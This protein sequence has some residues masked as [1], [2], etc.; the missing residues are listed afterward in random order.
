M[1][2]RNS[3]RHRPAQG[4]PINDSGESLQHTQGNDA[5]DELAAGDGAPRVHHREPA[6]VAVEED[7]SA[8]AVDDQTTSLAQLGLVPGV[9]LP[10]QGHQEIDVVGQRNADLPGGDHDI[11]AAGATA[12]LGPVDLGV[13]GVAPGQDGCFGEDSTGGDHT[14]ATR[15]G[16]PDLATTHR[17]GP[18]EYR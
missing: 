7:G 16:D 6:G 8:T 11:G 12:G 9:R 2:G 10:A 15:T 17:P 14:L 5:R 4:F 13:S 18:F 3:G 1:P